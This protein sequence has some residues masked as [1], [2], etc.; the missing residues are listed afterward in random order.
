MAAYTPFSLWRSPPLTQMNMDLIEW[1]SPKGRRLKKMMGV[2]G[3]RG[4][5]ICRLGFVR[6]ATALSRVRMYA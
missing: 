1:S 3:R 2:A 5:R 4:R 6:I